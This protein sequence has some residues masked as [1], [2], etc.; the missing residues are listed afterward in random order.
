V[1][2][3]VQASSAWLE[4]DFV[5]SICAWQAEQA[6]GVRG[7]VGSW[8]LWHAMHGLRGLW[9]VGLICGK[10]VGLDASYAWQ[11]GQNFRSRGAGGLTAPGSL[12]CVAAGP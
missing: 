6:A 5:R 12:A 7:G 3:V 8:G 11:T 10:P 9:T 4:T 1:W 2:H